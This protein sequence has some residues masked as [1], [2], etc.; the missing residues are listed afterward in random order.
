MTDYVKLTQQN[1]N[2]KKPK[3]PKKPIKEQQGKFE[4]YREVIT[5]N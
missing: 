1:N 2:Q 5:D 3:K 4:M